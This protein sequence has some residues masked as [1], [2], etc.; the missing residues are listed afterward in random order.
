MQAYFARSLHDPLLYINLQ[1][2]CCRVLLNL[3]ECVKAKEA[4]E[5]VNSREFILK[6]LQVFVLKF[7]SI[8]RYQVKHLLDANN[9]NSSSSCSSTTRCSPSVTAAV[10][11]NATTEN[12]HEMST[13]TIKTEKLDHF[14]NSYE[15]K[16]RVKVD[17][18]FSF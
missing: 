7:K 16:D 9:A 13:S 2:M 12:D 5:N 15:D 17:I 14:I 3:I 11:A 10:N 18:L 1:H 8:A 6:L 4:H